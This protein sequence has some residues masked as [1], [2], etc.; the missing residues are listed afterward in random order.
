MQC[1]F[2]V[3]Q[4]L[5]TEMQILKLEWMNEAGVKQRSLEHNVCQTCAGDLLMPAST[6]RKFLLVVSNA[7]PFLSVCCP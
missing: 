2:K 4:Y 5:S 6:M 1:L 3:T 7:V